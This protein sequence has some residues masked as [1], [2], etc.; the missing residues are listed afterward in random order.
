M[1]KVVLN[2]LVIPALTVAAAFTSCGGDNDNNPEEN[3][4]EKP[5]VPVITIATQPAASTNVTAGSITGS[6][7]V[8]A[9]VT[10]RATL[11]YQWHSA[12]NTIYEG[13]LSLGSAGGAQTNTLTI[14]TTL[15]AGTH[16][17][18]AK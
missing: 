8:T 3:P 2:Y 15:A 12:T 11:S 9:T 7:S 5:G 17:F 18:S 10:E 6:L 4:V 1:K 13:V 16:Y 14:S